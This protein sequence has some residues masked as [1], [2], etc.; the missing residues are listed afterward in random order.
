MNDAASTP[1]TTTEVYV[2]GYVLDLPWI[3]SEPENE[4]RSDG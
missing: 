2:P 4:G 3:D 1:P